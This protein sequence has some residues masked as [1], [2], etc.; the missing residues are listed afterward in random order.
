MTRLLELSELAIKHK[1]RII[2][3]QDLFER[4]DNERKEA[5]TTLFPGYNEHTN[6]SSSPK[7]ATLTEDSKIQVLEQTEH[8]IDNL[9][10]ILITRVQQANMHDENIVNIYIRPRATTNLVL[11]ALEWI[12][13]HT[14]NMSRIIMTGD[15]NST[16]SVW[17]EQYGRRELGGSSTEYDKVKADRGKVIKQ[18]IDRW[19]LT[20]LNEDQKHTTFTTNSG[21][22]SSTDI[23]LVGTKSARKWRK[24]QTICASNHG[25]ATLMISTP[26]NSTQ[27]GRPAKTRNT[28]RLDRISNSHIDAIKLTLGYLATGWDTLKEN[29]IITRMNTLT[30]N[31][32][33]QIQYI[34]SN[35]AITK[36]MRGRSYHKK[37]AI[38]DTLIQQRTQNIILKLKKL[39]LRRHKAKNSIRT[40]ARLNE[41]KNRLSKKLINRMLSA[42]LQTHDPTDVWD[43]WKAA[44]KIDISTIPDSLDIKCKQG[45]ERLAKEKFPSARRNL[46]TIVRPAETDRIIINKQEVLRAIQK[47]RNKKYNTPDGIKMSVFYRVISGIPD[48]MHSIASMSFYTGQIP[49]KAEFTQGTIIPKKAKGQFRIVHISNPI[50]AFLESIALARLDYRLELNRLISKNQFGFT[51]LRSRHDLAAKLIEYAQRMKEWGK[52]TCVVSMDI[53]GAFDNVNQTTLIE[54]LNTELK[55]KPLAKWIASFLNNRKISIHYQGIKTQYRT[56]CKGVPQGS[57]LGPVLWNFMIHNIEAGMMNSRRNT[58]LLKYA[59]DIYLATDGNDLSSTQKEIDDFV[60]TIKQLHLNVRPEKCSYMT[61]FERRSILGEPELLRINGQDLAKK[62]SMSILGIRISNDCHIDKNDEHLTNTLAR[63]AHTLNK[64][65]R[66]GLI[67]NNK[68]WRILIDGLINSRTITNYWPLLL[69]NSRDREWLLKIVIK[70]LKLTFDWPEDTPNKVIKLILDIREPGTTARR[71]ANGRLHLEQGDS[72]KYLMKNNNEHRITQQRRRYAN[73]ETTM[74]IVQYEQIPRDQLAEEVWYLLEGGKYAALTRITENN[75]EPTILHSAWYDACPYTNSLVT[76]TDA[77]RRYDLKRIQLIINGKCSIM[78][79]LCN[80]DNHDQRLIELR[81]LI[82]RAKWRI[83]ATNGPTHQAF[84]TTVKQFIKNKGIRTHLGDRVHNVNQWIRSN[85]EQQS[86]TQTLEATALK[87]PDTMDYLIRLLANKQYKM[88]SELERRSNRTRTCKEIEPDYRK[89]LS[90][91]PAHLNGRCMLMLGGLIKN[92]RITKDEPATRCHYCKQSWTTPIYALQHRMNTCTYFQHSKTTK[93]SKEI[94]ALTKI[95]IP[96]E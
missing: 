12:K 32:C 82:H 66:T 40:K 94:L 57:A 79:A 56:V 27:Q 69:I 47:L 15:V 46:M 68:H 44:D 39:E 55:D 19:K 42:Q 54:K 45:L 64:L 34:Q 16:A 67:R 51:A 75:I 41:R 1:P 14:R 63:V 76:L 60:R 22:I 37:R 83:I 21:L 96:N 95:A 3:I 78:Q 30:D 35:I 91:N 26:D 7:L 17:D 50:A 20:C 71:M 49:N 77:A 80:W 28:Y 74:N 85:I 8:N 58:L 11:S 23:T 90:L 65:K 9:I 89:W 53:E 38:T 43:T 25:H 59:D 29:Q 52:P 5:L 84:K 86:Q 2:C 92:R 88:A 70:T 93:L 31:L 36:K 13:T 87:S 18:W 81:E 61:M 24:L 72:Y 33:A 6:S 48:I 73:P 62:N 4:S 10:A